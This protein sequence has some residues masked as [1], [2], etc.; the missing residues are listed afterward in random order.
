MRVRNGWQGVAGGFHFLTLLS[1]VLITTSFACAGSPSAE[2]A[3]AISQSTATPSSAAG[4]ASASATPSP[5][6]LASDVQMGDTVWTLEGDTKAA[7]LVREQL[8]RLSFPSDAIG[9]TKSL[10][11]SIILG[12]GNTVR[13]DQRSMIAIDLRT[14]TS[15]ESRRDRFIRQS[16]LESD[17]YPFAVFVPRSVTG[18]PWP[19]PAEGQAQFQITGDLTAHGVTKPVTWDVAATFG[20]DTVSGEA[21]TSFP[22]SAFNMRIPRVAVLLSVDDNIRL[23]L[24]FTARKGIVGPKSGPGP[25]GP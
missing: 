18:L 24:D 5:T 4:L 3:A 6:P 16:S 13:T 2:P 10:E 20:K 25:A 8:A 22:F 9:V 11:G 15:D 23:R 19:I 17:R 21:T 1:A 14:L 12:P 7:Y